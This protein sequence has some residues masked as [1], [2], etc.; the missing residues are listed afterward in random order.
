MGRDDYAG[1]FAVYDREYNALLR[2]LAA[3][4]TPS[5]AA[6]LAREEQAFRDAVRRVE[7]GDADTPTL[8]PRDEPIA[9]VEASAAQLRGLVAGATLS[10]DGACVSSGYTSPP[11]LQWRARCAFPA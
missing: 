10:G 6:D 7:F 5:S 4:A 11:R 2:R 9:A 8:V 3:A 1:R